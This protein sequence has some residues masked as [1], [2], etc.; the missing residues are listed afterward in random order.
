M[1]D[2]NKFRILVVLLCAAILLVFTSG[3]PSAQDPPPGQGGRRGGGIRD[4]LGLGPAPDPVA[5]ERGQKL[6]AAS[7]AFCHGAKARGAEG[8]NLIRSVMVLHDERGELVGP[9]L[10]KGRPDKGMPAYPNLTESQT[11]DIAQFLHLQVELAANRGTYKRLNVVSGDA[12][13]GEAYFN[14]AGKCNTCHS[15]TGDLA[16]LGNKYPPDQIQNRFLWPGGGGFG[17][18]SYARKATV[19]LPDGQTVMG[20]IKRLDDFTVSLY[21]AAGNFHSWSR[22]DGKVK[23]AVEDR[24][25]AHRELL[26]QYTDADMHNLTAYLVTLK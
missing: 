3:N 26:D 13:K 7:C 20:T 16:K 17:A 25:K 4:F 10:L 9:F 5:A 14:G 22:E 11:S 21:D 12:K 2:P 19:T 18:P 23:V 15:P 6:Y 24:L 8:P 1:S